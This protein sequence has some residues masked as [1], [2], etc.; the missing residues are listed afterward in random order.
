MARTLDEIYQAILTE[1]ASQA[2][3]NG[4]TSNISD[5]QTLLN[6][7]TTGS[8]VA[9]WTLWAWITAVSIWTLEKLWDQYKVDV[10][11]IADRA[12]PGTAAWYAAQVL[13]FQYGDQVTV[14]DNVP[15]YATIDTSK[16]IVKR[17][18]IIEDGSGVLTI[19]VAKDNGG[20]LEPLSNAEQTAL[21]AYLNDIKFAGTRIQVISLNADKLRLTLTVHYDATLMNSD[22]KLISD[23]SSPVDD[24][25]DAYLAALPFNG[26][27]HER[28]LEDEIQQVAAV[29]DLEFTLLEATT[30]SNPWQSWTLQYMTT[31]GYA[32]ADT[33]NITYIADV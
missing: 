15:Q 7:L 20:V 6:E 2:T 33:L 14:I 25:I 27:V 18:A 24:A 22:G 19:K 26:V 4:L 13:A 21:E 10:Q 17:V 11:A 23:G 12:V 9:V 31:A 28:G 5:Q 1:K 8:R 30:G 16:R 32:V 29:S 3:L